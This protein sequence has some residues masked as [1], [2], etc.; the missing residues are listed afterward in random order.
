MERALLT[1]F[2]FATDMRRREGSKEGTAYKS[3][4][5]GAALFATFSRAMREKVGRSLNR[6]ENSFVGWMLIF[7]TKRIPTWS[8][9][10]GLFLHVE[11]EGKT[12][13]RGPLWKSLGLDQ[14][15]AHSPA[16]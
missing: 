10:G 6:K 5:L 9:S 11:K 14:A 16:P 1:S 13:Q 3:P 8:A 15:L 7:E 4:L 12:R 2:I